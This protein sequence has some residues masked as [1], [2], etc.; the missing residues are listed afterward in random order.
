MPKTFNYKYSKCRCFSLHP[1]EILLQIPYIGYQ[2]CCF[3][4]FVK[5]ERYLLASK[6][7]ANA[8][9]TQSP[10]RTSV[11]PLVHTSRETGPHS[12]RTADTAL[13]YCFL[14]LLP[15]LLLVLLVGS[16]NY[17]ACFQTHILLRQKGY[18]IAHVYYEQHRAESH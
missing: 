11:K 14:T 16:Y 12:A 8:T 3:L 4:F 9:Q 6:Q 2:H 18:V 15:D 5:N 1:E 10:F 17:A 13:W 7:N